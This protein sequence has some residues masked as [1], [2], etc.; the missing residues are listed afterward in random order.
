[1]LVCS[2]DAWLPLIRGYWFQAQD[3]LCPVNWAALQPKPPVL[4]RITS[5]PHHNPIALLA[6]GWG[7]DTTHLPKSNF[8]ISRNRALK[9]YLHAVSSVTPTQNQYFLPLLRKKG[10]CELNSFSSML[11]LPVCSVLKACAQQCYYHPALFWF[12]YQDSI[13]SHK[14]CMKFLPI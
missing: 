6:L 4:D 9:S 3:I 14:N 11:M 13:I 1:M 8:R 5:W 2:F 12:H 10:N 7:L